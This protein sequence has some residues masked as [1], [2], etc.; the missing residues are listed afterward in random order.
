MSVRRRRL[1]NRLAFTLSGL[2][3]RGGVGGGGGV[4]WTLIS[5]GLPGLTPTVFTQSTPAPGSAGGL[6]NAIVGSVLMTLLGIA[7]TALF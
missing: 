7:A 3:A 6:A 4:L 5:R 2:G 1:M